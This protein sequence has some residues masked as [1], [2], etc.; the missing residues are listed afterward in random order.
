LGE[1]EGVY[2][3]AISKPNTS[4]I[5]GLAVG[6]QDV[7]LGV[8]FGIEFLYSTLPSPKAFS[9]WLDDASQGGFGDF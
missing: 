2:G 5:R 3:K 9:D 8:G 7:H 1:V 4:P 6:A